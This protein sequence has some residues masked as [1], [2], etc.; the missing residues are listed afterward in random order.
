MIKFTIFNLQVIDNMTRGRT[1]F[2]N[3][4]TLASK[5]VVE[6]RISEAIKA[7]GIGEVDERLEREIE[8]LEKKM[9][10]MAEFEEKNELKRRL[11]ENK[12]KLLA[13]QQQRRE[14]VT[15]SV[16]AQA[17]MS[18]EGSGSDVM[19][20]IAQR[21]QFPTSLLGGCFPASATF[22]D[23]Q[24]RRRSMYSL[25]IGEEV[26]VLKGKGISVEPVLT[27]IHRQPDIMQKYLKITTAK[28]E[29]ILKI[30]EDHLLFVKKD[31]QPT[32]IPARDVSIGDTVFVR[33]DHDTMETDTVQS[34]RFVFEKGV[35]APVTLTGTILVDDVHTSCYFDLLSHD[36]SHRAMGI[37]R[38]VYH[39]SPWM[40]QWLSSIGQ[41]DGFP[42]W[43]RVAHKVL[44][45]LSFL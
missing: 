31:D 16:Q 30:T 43:C 45:K 38:A 29:K 26:Q 24:G 5:E 22:T 39:V 41:K 27:Y 35:Y 23:K 40:V 18:I 9:K 32:T 1:P 2:T 3:R 10:D 20:K 37:A 36:W 8:D 17:K 28:K 15:R 21:Q 4:L 11:T 12:G 7:S 14:L 33:G 6:E 44:R 19:L 42:G 34:I 13:T 25:K